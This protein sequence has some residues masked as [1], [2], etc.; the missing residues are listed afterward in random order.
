MKVAFIIFL[1]VYINRNL[2][3]VD[4][5]QMGDSDENNDLGTKFKIKL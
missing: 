4:Q 1:L 2:A 5:I 3:D